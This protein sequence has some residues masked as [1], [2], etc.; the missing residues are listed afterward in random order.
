MQPT[1]VQ[2]IWPDPAPL[3]EDDLSAAYAVDRTRPSVRMNFVTS[4]DGA[5]EVDGY[6][7]GLSDPADQRVLH[8]LRVHA[9]AVMVGAGTLRH[10]GYG[11]MRLDPAD[12]DQR[13]AHGL[14][15]HPT[16]VIVSS[17]L[18]LDPGHRAFTTAPVRPV[19]LT[20]GAAPADRR[21]ALSAVADVLE[22]GD[23]TVDQLVGLAAL[24]DR[25]LDHVLCEGGPHLFGALLAADAVDELCLTLSPLLA[26]SGAGRIVADGRRAT[27]ARMRLVHLLAAGDTLLSRYARD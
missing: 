3:D 6:S 11:A 24:H 7:R 16:L 2:R 10:E 8:A 12:Q 9:D 27:P 22:C 4:L 18:A 5:V 23:S 15:A 17:S 19:V 26:G 21:T 20:H 14:A 13:T 1:G 25:G